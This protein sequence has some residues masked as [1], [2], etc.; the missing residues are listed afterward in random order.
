MVKVIETTEEF[1]ALLHS[2]A[3]VVVDFYADWYV[4]HLSRFYILYVMYIVR[5]V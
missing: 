1:N 2:G 4:Q 5:L 3:T